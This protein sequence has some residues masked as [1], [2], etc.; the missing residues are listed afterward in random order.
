VSDVPIPKQGEPFT[1]DDI[2]LPSAD[3]DIVT[4]TKEVNKADGTK[5]TTKRQ[6]MVANWHASVTQDD[7]KLPKSET[8][9]G[10]VGDDGPKLSVPTFKPTVKAVQD[11]HNKV[12]FKTGSQRS[13]GTATVR[14]DLITPVGLRRLAETYQEGCKYGERNWE[15]GQPAGTVIN[16]AM[17]HIVQWLDGDQSEDHLAHAAWNLFAI[18]HFEEKMPAMIDVPS[19]ISSRPAS[20]RPQTNA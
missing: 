13:N 17:K 5:E 16:H 1:F 10:A 20:D 19:R 3:Y 8:C 9:N 6:Y 18:M 11:E 7:V 12:V 15:L 4:E 2:E 14:Y